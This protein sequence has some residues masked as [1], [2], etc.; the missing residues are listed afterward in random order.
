MNFKEYRDY[1]ALGLAQLIKNRDVSPLEL[2]NIAIARTEDVNPKL[3]AVVHK[4]YDSA[5][6][7]L[8]NLDKEAIFYGVPFLMKDIGT[9]LKGA[10]MSFGC[11]GYGNFIST[12]DSIVT[13]HIKKA[14]LITFAK[15][16]TPEFGLTP[17]T[18]PE[19]FGPT[20]NPWNTEHSAGGSS[21][22]SASGVAAGISP[23]ATAND[24]GGSIRI[25]AS[26]CGLFGLKPSRGRVSLGPVSSES[27]SGAV[28]ENCVSRSVRDSAAYLDAIQGYGYGEPYH[29][30][31]PALPYLQE[32]EKVPGK[33]KIAFS[34][35]HSLGHPVD[36]ECIDATQ[37]TAKLLHNLGHEVE[38][39]KLP[40]HKDD[41]KIAF[42]TVIFGEVAAEIAELEKYLG[43]KVTLKDVEINTLSMGLLGKTYRAVDFAK[44]KRQWGK[45][46]RTIGM[47][48]QKYDLM[49]TPTV[50]SVPPK[51]GELLN[52]KA[53]D[54]L[55]KTITSLGFGKLLKSQAD[56]IA[57]K[58]FDYI[59]YTPI[60]NMT[61]QPS[62]SVPLHW[63]NNNLPVGVMFTGRMGEENILFRLAAQLEEA[64]PWFNKI[65]N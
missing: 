2:L 14:G 18:E 3:N 19:L 34:T 28:M 1:D 21:G 11:R 22:G 48:H 26:C 17:Y 9:H 41:L 12:E 56:K 36:Q 47:F 51:I 42:A 60:A 24:G 63:S 53:E 30:K 59:P 23:I 49:L 4:L 45:L 27:W 62:M 13:A 44:A 65:P 38:E 58:T 25:P 6:A 32:I 29:F 50:A 61:G 16:N 31:S 5:K 54:S 46:S 35:E 10:P 43:R 55:A 15:T 64:Q 33:L 39:V 7:D 20:K 37:N 8:V 40:W 57:E 52:S